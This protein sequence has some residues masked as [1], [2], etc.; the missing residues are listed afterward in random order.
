MGAKAAEGVIEGAVR[1]RARRR[2]DPLARRLRRLLA[3][4]Q[5]EF[6]ALVD[7]R[8][9]TV[10]RWEGGETRPGAAVRE[11]MEYLQQLAESLEGVLDRKRIAEWLRTP[12]P[13]LLDQPPLDLIRSRF[14]RRVLEAE[15][16]RA[17]WGIPG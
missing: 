3:V 11:K 13:E 6:A 4:S 9:R 16:E 17:G 10:A 15:I 2:G 14:G 1:P 12:N 7:V 8:A 5:E